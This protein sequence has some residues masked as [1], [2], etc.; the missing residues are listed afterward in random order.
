MC[1]PVEDLNLVGR[2]NATTC[3]DVVALDPPPRGLT[4]TLMLITS[5]TLMP[6]VHS[7][8]VSS[9]DYGRLSQLPASAP[10]APLSS[11]P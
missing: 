4:S 9:S 3:Y 7:V 6:D 2:S 8:V 5:P 1:Y 10:R 11:Q